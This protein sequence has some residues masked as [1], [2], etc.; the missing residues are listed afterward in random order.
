[1]EKTMTDKKKEE[2]AKKDAAPT[3]GEIAK[4]TLTGDLRDAILQIVQAQK[5][6]WAQ[7]SEQ[8][9]TIVVNNVQQRVEHMVTKVV[10]IIS[11]D[12]RKM[13]I[14]KLDSIT[15]KDGF[16]AVLSLSK[17]SEMAHDLVDSQGSLVALVVAD[18]EAYTGEKA[19]AK[20]DKDQKELTADDGKSVFDSSKAGQKDNKKIA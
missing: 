3:G 11:A 20:V 13:I 18:R 5:K 16:K 4:K 19:P 15:V 7:L 14:A 10:D 17:Y 12:G 9:Q 2:P 6:P 8:E 1:M